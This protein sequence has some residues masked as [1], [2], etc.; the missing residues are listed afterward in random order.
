MPPF[1]AAAASAAIAD[2]VKNAIV[3]DLHISAKET[4]SPRSAFVKSQKR[5]CQSKT[6]QYLCNLKH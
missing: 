1:I 3:T 6:N 4:Q 2:A 5:H